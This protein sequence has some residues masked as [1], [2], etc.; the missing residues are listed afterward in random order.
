MHAPQHS[1]SPSPSEETGDG[2]GTHEV[3]ARRARW[4][5][6]GGRPTGAL[7]SR[8]RIGSRIG[9][10]NPIGESRE[11]GLRAIGVTEATSWHAY[12]RPI[13]RAC[14]CLSY[15]SLSLMRVSR[16]SCTDS[17]QHAACSC[18]THPDCAHPALTP[19]CSEHNHTCGELELRPS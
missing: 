2:G 19:L 14:T 5:L 11:S 16:V 4:A 1:D 9:F 18:N 17:M 15:V 8:R 3:L 6:R 13:S 7:S 10:R 12:L